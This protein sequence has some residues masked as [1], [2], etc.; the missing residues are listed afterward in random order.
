MADA[1]RQQPRREIPPPARSLASPPPVDE[2]G[3]QLVTNKR[4]LRSEI[5]R[6]RP[7]L[8]THKRGMVWMLW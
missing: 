1:R 5:R 4:R 6:A 2:D 3:V 8:S 7:P